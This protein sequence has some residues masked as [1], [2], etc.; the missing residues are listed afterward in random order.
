MKKIALFIKDFRR[1]TKISEKLVDL[2]N[3]IRF[4][5]T[6]LD[7]ATDCSLAIIDLNESDFANSEFISRLKMNSNI[8]VIGYVSKVVKKS[9]DTF[10]L[11]GCDIILSNASILKNIER[12]TRE[13]LK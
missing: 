5:E 10:K 1:A 9:H 3:E 12:L 7:D 6:T 11:S 13:A 2:N 4:F 8:Y